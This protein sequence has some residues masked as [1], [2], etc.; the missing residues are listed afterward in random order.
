[1]IFILNSKLLR[2][3]L[4][5]KRGDGGKKPE[6][7]ICVEWAF[8]VTEY[9]EGSREHWPVG[10][11]FEWSP[12][13]GTKHPFWQRPS[14]SAALSQVGLLLDLS[15][16]QPHHGPCNPWPFSV[17]LHNTPIS[18]CQRSKTGV[19]HSAYLICRA[20]AHMFGTHV[21]S[22]PLVVILQILLS[23]LQAEGTLWSK[24]LIEMG[25]NN[26]F[27]NS[28]LCW[29]SHVNTGLLVLSCSQV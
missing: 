14:F 4:E 26:Q 19:S 16:Q 2:K 21:L 11:S 17:S 8:L 22:C 23:P 3:F 9:S 25:N 10:S 1:M 24:S 12:D 13:S 28:A 18:A 27:C 20:H 6:G 29:R 15:S 5:R 7:A